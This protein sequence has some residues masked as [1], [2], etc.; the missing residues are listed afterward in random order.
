MRVCF[1]IHRLFSIGGLASRE[2]IQVKACLAAGFRTLVV[3]YDAPVSYPFPD[4]FNRPL[5]RHLDVAELF[6]LRR[7]VTSLKP[8]V[9]HVHL[10]PMARS[11]FARYLNE[12]GFRVVVDLHGLWSEH[13]YSAS[14]REALLRGLFIPHIRE[15]DRVAVT[16]EVLVEYLSRFGI[17]RRK[18]YTLPNAVDTN[19]FRPMRTRLKEKLSKYRVVTFVGGTY[20]A[21]HLKEIIRAFSLAS[22]KMPSLFLVLAIYV[23]DKRYFKETLRM[24]RKIPRKL[25][26]LNV[27]D[28][29]P[30]IA[31]A[32]L[33]LCFFKR[34]LVG[35]TVQP[36]KLLEYMAMGK[37]V[38]ATDN[39]VISQIVK[40][41]RNGFLCKPDVSE[42]ADKIVWLLENVKEVREIG[43]EAR[44]TIVN[45][46]SLNV[47]A[48]KLRELYYSLSE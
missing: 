3:S 39:K 9:F 1:I 46:Y 21:D 23:L 24:L 31:C 38:L 4:Q 8:D 42:F 26:A 43:E 29:R 12:R 22:A 40:N 45:N 47:L 17:H 27:R 35:E 16:S 7:V 13:A 33:C 19:Y 5:L 6:L 37:P 10:P 15:V 28:V 48:T 44:R 32:D 34:S 25:V 18:F 36:I 11:I 41:G 20:S 30:Y 2:R 14:P